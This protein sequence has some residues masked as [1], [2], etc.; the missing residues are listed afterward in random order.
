MN[1][2]KYILTVSLLLLLLV[3]AETCRMKYF[4]KPLKY[5]ELPFSLAPY[6]DKIDPQFG[7]F[8]WQEDSTFYFVFL[9]DHRKLNFYNAGDKTIAGII[10]MEKYLKGLR[11]FCC[12][13]IGK[14]LW[15]FDCDHKSLLQFN[16]PDKNNISLANTY[17][18]DSLLN[19]KHYF[20]RYQYRNLFEVK[21]SLLFLSYGIFDR[22]TY[23][24]DST[25]WLMLNLFRPDDHYQLKKIF[26]YPD[27]YQKGWHYNT[28]TWLRFPGENTVLSGFASDNLLYKW[29]PAQNIFTENRFDAAADFR[30]FN[31]NKINDLSYIRWYIFTDECND[32][33]ITLNNNSLL[34]LK[35]LP[36]SEIAD[37]C[38]YEY[39][40]L[41]D[42][43]AVTSHNEFRQEIHPYFC[44]PWRQGFMIFAEDLSKAY[45]Y[46]A[47]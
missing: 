40:V 12:R 46:A 22:S 19:W 36:R 25:A 6:K 1:P 21:D 28:D 39:Y 41:D 14:Q 3:I 15:L 13:I 17:S 23:D 11:L 47:N 34:V 4:T 18:L 20:L 7:S 8:L 30:K 37:A 44:Y 16:F 24:L 35:R 26:R 31:W 38:R 5:S 45:Y 43:L 32:N 33:V 42:N 10:D 2:K 29:L 9:D 27:D